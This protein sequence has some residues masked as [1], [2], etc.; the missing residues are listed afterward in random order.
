MLFCV[1]QAVVANGPSNTTCGRMGPM[2]SNS[3]FSDRRSTISASL[4]GDGQTAECPYIIVCPDH[5]SAL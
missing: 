3:S 5:D 4:Q 2:Q 1:P